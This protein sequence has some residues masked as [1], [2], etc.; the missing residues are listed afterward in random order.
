MLTNIDPS[1]THQIYPCQGYISKQFTKFID[2]NTKK[3]SK[4]KISEI[5]LH[6]IIKNIYKKIWIPRCI[7]IN[8]L[9]TEE[10]PPVYLNNIHL[11]TLQEPEVL[12][13]ENLNKI[14]NRIKQ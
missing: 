7:E 11:N 8:N 13:E 5:L 4:H 6:K 9:N 10:Q 2:E 1:S 14:I 3:N 12:P